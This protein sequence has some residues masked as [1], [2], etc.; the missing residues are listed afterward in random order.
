MRLLGR[1]RWTERAVQDMLAKINA[2]ARDGDTEAS[3]WWV[4]EDVV[5]M[6]PD[7]PP[8]VARRACCCIPR[9]FVYTVPTE[10]IGDH[11]VRDLRRRVSSL[12]LGTGP[13]GIAGI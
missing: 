9:P 12:S 4:A 1:V 3:L 13:H 2:A 10:T 6:P 8:V 5:S 7:Q 11:T